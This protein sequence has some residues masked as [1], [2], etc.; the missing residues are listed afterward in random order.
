MKEFSILAMSL[1]G[2]LIAVSLVLDNMMG[3]F[4]VCILTCVF[5]DTVRSKRTDKKPND[6][7]S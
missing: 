1:A 5:L 4:I 7:E 2:I 6:K 3:I